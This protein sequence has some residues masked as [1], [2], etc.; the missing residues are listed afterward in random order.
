MTIPARV[1]LPNRFVKTPAGAARV[2]R[3]SD[4][5]NPFHVTRP[6]GSSQFIVLW[7]GRKRGDPALVPEWADLRYGFLHRQHAHA[8]AVALY[9]R[10]LLDG[11]Q[12]GLRARVEAELAGRDLACSCPAPLACHTQPLLIVAN[13]ITDKRWK[14][15]IKVATVPEKAK[16]PSGQLLFRFEDAD[17]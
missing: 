16:G 13:G 12:A 17:P 11:D 7:R 5:G 10:W 1:V 9:Y 6:D 3:P 2:M 14:P 15:A 4:F 8:C